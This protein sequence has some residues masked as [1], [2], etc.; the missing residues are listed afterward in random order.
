MP[1]NAVKVYSGASHTRWLS[2]GEAGS[3]GQK[4]KMDQ[5]KTKL[6]MH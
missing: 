3:R 1:W 6:E 2:P 4:N 5:T